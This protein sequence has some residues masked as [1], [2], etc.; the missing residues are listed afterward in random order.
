MR[1]PEGPLLRPAVDKNIAIRSQNPH[2]PDHLHAGSM[3]LPQDIIITVCTHGSGKM[4]G[5]GA[6][7]K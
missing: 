5:G 6:M 3:S 2:N 7:E 1:G 4:D